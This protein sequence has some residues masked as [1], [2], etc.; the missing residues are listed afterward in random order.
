MLRNTHRAVAVLVGVAAALFASGAAHAQ[1]T[2]SSPDGKSAIS[3][4]FL[5]QMQ[6]EAIE[7]A[8][9]TGCEQNL[10]FRRLRL[11]GGGRIGSR[12]SFFFETDSPNLGK[13]TTTGSK[14]AGTVNL[15]DFVLTYALDRR[16]KL[17]GG[18]LLLP[19]SHNG[20]QGATSLLPVDYGPYT[21]SHSDPLNLSVGRDYGLQARG[22]LARNHFEY[23]VGVSQGNRGTD[24]RRPLCSFARAVWYPF[25]ADTGL[26]Y[27]GTTLGKRRIV[28]V[29]ASLIAQQRFLTWSGDVFLDL[30][31]GGDALTCQFDFTRFDGGRTFPSLDRQDDYLVE[32]GY[33]F[34]AARLGPFVQYARRDYAAAGLADESKLQGG[35]AWWGEGHRFNLKLGVAR[36]TKERAE[37]RNQFLLQW[38]TLMF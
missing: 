17:D 13:G 28:A 35:V 20:Q 24:S 10:F 38:Q 21:F 2:V 29:G 14:T 34:H 19:V 31:L 22:Y 26:F 5:S 6:F 25:D 30:P 9:G 7:T 37:D 8:D 36:L 1:W 11:M 33:L 12:I 18:M 15:Q 16:I 32:G 4:G 23:R 27:T 3:I